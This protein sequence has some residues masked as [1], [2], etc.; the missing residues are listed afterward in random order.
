MPPPGITR[1]NRHNWSPHLKAELPH[2]S[3]RQQS[4]DFQLMAEAEA[5]S[6]FKQLQIYH[7]S[8][9]FLFPR[10]MW[11]PGE[12]PRLG[13]RCL[14]ESGSCPGATGSRAGCRC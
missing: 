11:L 9:A 3:S 4:V 7:N 13:R 14:G 10:R 6:S 8:P 2:P 5:A 1:P 12:A